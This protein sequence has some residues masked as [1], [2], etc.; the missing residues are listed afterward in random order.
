VKF[1]HED[2]S[3]W[4]RPTT[5]VT[6]E[7]DAVGLDE[8]LEVFERFLRAVGFTLPGELDFAQKEELTDATE[9]GEVKEND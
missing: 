8:V 2:E 6:V 3:S 7:T 4:G 5:S 1:T 9:T